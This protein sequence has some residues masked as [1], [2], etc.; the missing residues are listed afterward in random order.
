MPSRPSWVARSAD[1]S[2]STPCRW[3]ALAQARAAASSTAP[4]TCWRSSWM[5]ARPTS[6][7]P[8]R[9][10]RLSALALAR[11]LVTVALPISSL[12]SLRTES[13]LD[14][15]TSTVVSRPSRGAMRSPIWSM[16]VRSSWRSWS[17][18]VAPTSGRPSC[19]TARASKL[20]ISRSR[21]TMG[22]GSLGAG[23]SPCS[24]A[25][26]APG[27]GGGGVTSSGRRSSGRCKSTPPASGSGGF[28]VAGGDGDLRTVGT[29]P[30][31]HRSAPADGVG[32][33]GPRSPARPRPARLAASGGC[34]GGLS[35]G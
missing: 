20:S 22:S 19:P 17:P 35:D 32:C 30:R 11:R 2:P 25:E 7:E 15:A 26:W 29:S 28:I 27:A 6:T 8:R 23:G 5:A 21:V 1:S 34:R 13:T 33:E 31:R 3:T 12:S 9:S 10:P 14:S 24:A 18:M 4:S 16:R